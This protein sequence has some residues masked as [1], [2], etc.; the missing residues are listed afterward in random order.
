MILP[1]CTNK[2]WEGMK[3]REQCSSQQCPL[4]EQR[5]WHKLKHIKFHLN[6]RKFFTMRVGGQTVQQVAQRGF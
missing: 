1:V 3:V 4:A 2:G 6:T 5:R